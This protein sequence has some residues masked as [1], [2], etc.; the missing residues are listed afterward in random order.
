[1]QRKFFFRVWMLAAFLVAG[2]SSAQAQT[3][4]YR[5][6][7]TTWANARP[8]SHSA[9]GLHGLTWTGDVRIE[10]GGMKWVNYTSVL[11]VPVTKGQSVQFLFKS[12]TEGK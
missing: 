10:S 8:L 4:N 7:F 12:E 11:S 1:M 3:D 2:L 6:D 5:W 9:D